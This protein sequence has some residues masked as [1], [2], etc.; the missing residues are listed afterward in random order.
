MFYFRICIR[1]ICMCYTI[2][3]LFFFGGFGVEVG[4]FV[5]SVF[6]VEIWGVTLVLFGLEFFGGVGK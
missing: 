1:R 6:E 4:G 2:L 5:S 3:A